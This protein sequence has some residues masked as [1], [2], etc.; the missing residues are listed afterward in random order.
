[1][2]SVFNRLVNGYLTVTC[3]LL[4]SI[5]NVICVKYVHTR[6]G[7]DGNRGASLAV[8]LSLLAFWDTALLWCAFGYYGWKNLI[9]PSV[10]T[11]DTASATEQQIA[12]L[13]TPAFHA[14]SQ[15]ANTASV[16]LFFHFKY[17][18]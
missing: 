10:A 8:A 18:N 4:G 9:A 2:F 13:M 15:I 11:S 12:V 6:M 3:V 5:G 14:L 1:M 7:F 17:S 16:Y